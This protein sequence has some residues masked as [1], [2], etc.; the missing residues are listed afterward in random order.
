M[1]FIPIMFMYIVWALISIPI[2]VGFIIASGR[3]HDT[4]T[5][6]HEAPRAARATGRRVAG[7]RARLAG[8]MHLPLH[9]G[10]RSRHGH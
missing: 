9:H 7:M 8:L 4:T 3:D 6:A 5:G 2:I 10:P 1:Q